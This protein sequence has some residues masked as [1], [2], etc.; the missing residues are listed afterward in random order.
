MIDQ[1]AG[2]FANRLGSYLVT[3]HEDHQ[4]IGPLGGEESANLVLG[5]TE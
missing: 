4:H 3:V 2:H 1:E 5:A